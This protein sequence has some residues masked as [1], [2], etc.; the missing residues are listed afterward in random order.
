MVNLP[1]KC[2]HLI[3]GHRLVDHARSF[4]QKSGKLFRFCKSVFVWVH[5]HKRQKIICRLQFSDC[6][7]KLH[8]IF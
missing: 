2:K 4:R 1:D 8:L 3:F 7:L 6:I 5:L